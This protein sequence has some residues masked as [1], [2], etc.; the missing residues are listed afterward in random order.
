MSGGKPRDFLKNSIEIGQTVKIEE[1]TDVFNADVAVLQHFLCL[2]DFETGDILNGGKP[3]LLAELF[4][5]S[6][7]AEGAP[8]GKGGNA[9]GFGIVPIYVRDSVAVGF[10]KGEDAPD[11]LI[12]ARLYHGGLPVFVKLRG[13]VEKGE[14]SAVVVGDLRNALV[15]GDFVSC[16]VRQ[17]ER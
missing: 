8:F 4:S 12:G 3:R 10:L 14:Q 6:R 15:Y 17:K 13:R 9:E 5:V 11:N 2:F 16:L 7:L 1:F